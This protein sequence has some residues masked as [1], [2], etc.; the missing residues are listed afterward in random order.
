MTIVKAQP[1]GDGRITVNPITYVIEVKTTSH[2][3]GENPIFKSDTEPAVKTVN[4][5]WIDKSGVTTYQLKCW[6]GTNWVNV[7]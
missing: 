5:L 2:N 7:L 6:N 4:M 1:V 3:Y